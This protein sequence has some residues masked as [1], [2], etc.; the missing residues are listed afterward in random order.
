[1]QQE[2]LADGAAAAAA[3]GAGRHAD[4]GSDVESSTAVSDLSAYA[5]GSTVATSDTGSGM[6]ASTVGGRRP[7]R[8]ARQ[9]VGCSCEAGWSWRMQ[10]SLWDSLRSHAAVTAGTLPVMMHDQARKGARIRKGGP[11]EELALAEHLA[12]LAPTPQRLAEAGAL[13]EALVCGNTRGCLLLR[14]QTGRSCTAASLALD[15]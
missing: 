15:Q 13:A 3:G 8:T 4:S 9:K 11:G 5:A 1:M 6:P 7:A 14:P 10:L 2:H 12:S